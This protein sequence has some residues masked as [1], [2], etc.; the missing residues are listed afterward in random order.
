VNTKKTY[1]LGDEVTVSIKQTNLE[2]RQMDF[3]L[4]QASDR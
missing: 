4:I 1:Q 2:K 3:N